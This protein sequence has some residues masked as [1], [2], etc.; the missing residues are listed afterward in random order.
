MGPFYAS[1][2]FKTGEEILCYVKSANP[3]EDILL[4]EN[5]VEVEEVDIPGI[6]QGM[7][8]KLWMKVSHE[9][10]FYI[11]GDTITTIK[12]VNTHVINFY[13]SCIK[14]LDEVD[15]PKKRIKK[16]QLKREKGR[17][18][19]DSNMGLLSSIDDA[20]DLLE[21]VFLKDIK[22]NKES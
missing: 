9:S 13:K 5:P 1:I 10:E 3:E 2:K 7:K 11:D 22:D 21:Q 12:E 15:V 20:R 4:I 8:L 17:I 18:P 14:R 19:L 16:P 6:I